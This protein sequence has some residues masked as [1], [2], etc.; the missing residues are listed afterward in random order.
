MRLKT[1]TPL[2]A[3]TSEYCQDSL[4]GLLKITE[5]DLLVQSIMNSSRLGRIEPDI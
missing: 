3:S 1:I 5:T 2:Y 4:V